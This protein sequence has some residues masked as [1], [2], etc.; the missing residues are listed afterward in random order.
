MFFLQKA[1]LLKI[2]D[3]TSLPILFVFN[4]PKSIG[5]G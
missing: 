5:S 1:K 2:I 4:K 3:E